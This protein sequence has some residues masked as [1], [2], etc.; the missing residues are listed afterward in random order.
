MN[1]RIGAVNEEFA[2]QITGAKAPHKYMEID[3]A[4][5]EHAET[6]RILR[7]DIR[8]NRVK[9][10]FPSGLNQL[11]LFE[12]CRALAVIDNPRIDYDTRFQAMYDVTMQMLEKKDLGIYL[13]L[14][15]G[16]E[17]ELCMAHV[18]NRFQD[19][20]GYNV[21]ANYPCLIEWL[22]QFIIEELVKKFPLPGSVP[23]QNQAAEKPTKGKTNKK[24]GT[25]SSSK[26]Q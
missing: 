10:K 4:V 12:E 5:L 2:A 17:K 19:L 9:Y 22:I 13:V 18:T 7:E 8:M 23:A 3:A 20:T 1:D 25:G 16:T 6:V 14:D 24:P 11:T 21:I 26:G 15:D